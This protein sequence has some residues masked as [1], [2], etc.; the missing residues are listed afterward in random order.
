MPL[1][2]LRNGTRGSPMMLR[3]TALVADRLAAAHPDL[4][5]T[6]D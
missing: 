6:G 4:A 5:A 1:R 2:P 3:Q